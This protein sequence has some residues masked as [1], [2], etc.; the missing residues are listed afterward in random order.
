MLLCMSFPIMVYSNNAS[1]ALSGLQ[2][3]R[4]LSSSDSIDMNISVLSSRRRNVPSLL[5]QSPSSS[6]SPSP[7]PVA[8][9]LQRSMLL[10][11]RGGD[12][13][14]SDDEGEDD[15]AVVDIDEDKEESE[16]DSDDEDSDDEESEDESEEESEEE[17]DE[18][19]DSD[20]E[21]S[22][23]EE[24]EDVASTPLSSS[25]VK[26]IIR[27]GLKSSL[28]D[29]SIELTC[30][31]KRDVASLKTSVSRQMRGR[32]PPSTLTLL[33]H[34]R[35][36]SDDELVDELAPDEDDDDED[37]ADDDD[38]D[39]VKLHL[40]LDNVPPI[41]PKFATELPER[42]NKMSDS[43]LLDA[44][45]TN[46]IAMQR[47]NAQ[48]LKTSLQSSSVSGANQDDD[49]EDDENEKEESTSS[50]SSSS[51]TM[52]PDSVSMRMDAMTMR[53]RMMDSFPQDVV[54]RLM[55]QKE[56]N[57]DET[58][59]TE[60]QQQLGSGGVHDASLA[61]SIKRKG[62]KSN[63]A[64]KGG[65]TMNVKRT[66]QRNLNINWP[67]TIRNFFLFLFFGYFGGRN[68]ASRTLMLLCAPMCF[69]IQARPVKI[70]LK[71]LFY[72][73]GKPPSIFLSLLPAPQ[74]TIMS[75]DY[76]HALIDI[77]GEETA[78]A[79]A[80]AMGISLKMDN[81]GSDVDD[82]NEDDFME[83]DD[84]DDD[85]FDSDEYDDDDDY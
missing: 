44:Y 42:M 51:T 5:K 55:D 57:L 65:A 12:T 72:A 24:E 35:A 29:Q 45:V 49:D 52:L 36:L 15:E 26:V 53:E 78:T 77:Y 64:I 63:M 7:L 14:I 47:N 1:P 62:R 33:H 56:G 70:A 82:D 59:D 43:D 25:P 17:E 84:D 54:Q 8:F 32:P 31:R 71:Q 27:T 83:S 61:E 85:D 69:I 9:S 76:T 66:L 40:M 30:S 46:V 2:L 80:E 3:H 50:S 41:D 20:D 75:L 48:L 60:G 39:M 6:S 68:T 81:D 37:Y 18:M 11:L 21:E 34:N 79:A 38:D 19:E 73:I 16:D 28:L 74:Q 23:E 13:E 4:S 22:E 58:S 10:T 67:D